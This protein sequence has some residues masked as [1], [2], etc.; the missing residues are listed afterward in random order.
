MIQLVAAQV[1]NMPV[2]RASMI[3]AGYQRI[4]LDCTSILE[5]VAG[6]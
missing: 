6:W 1:A 5:P 3:A 2:H 4:L